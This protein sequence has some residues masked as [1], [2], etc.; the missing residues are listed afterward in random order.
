M[1]THSDED[2]LLLHPY[3]E[4]PYF[5]CEFPHTRFF[6]FRKIIDWTLFERGM[7]NVCERSLY[8]DS[9]VVFFYTRRVYAPAIP[10]GFYEN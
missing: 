7:C 6:N 8:H 1:Y 4:T 3:Y 9:S 2:F 10:M 5:P